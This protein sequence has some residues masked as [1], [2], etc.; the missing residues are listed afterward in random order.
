MAQALFND[1][2][3]AQRAAGLPQEWRNRADQLLSLTGDPR[4]HAIAIFCHNLT[5][6]FHVDLTGLSTLFSL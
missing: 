2:G 5:Y 6:L 4:R 1:L 3:S